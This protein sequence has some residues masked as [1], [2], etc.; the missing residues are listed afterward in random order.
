[1]VAVEKDDERVRRGERRRI[2]DLAAQA[3][4]VGSGNAVEA[5][6]DGGL[7]RSRADSVNGGR[8][9][10]Q[11]AR[12]GHRRLDRD[13]WRAAGVAAV[14][15]VARIELAVASEVIDD[16][17]A[18]TYATCV[19]TQVAYNTTVK[20]LFVELPPFERHRAEYLD[21]EGFS[22]LQDELMTDPDAATSSRERAV[23][24]RC[25]T[26]IR[27]A[28]RA[29]VEAC[30]SSTTGGKQEGSSGSSRCTTRTR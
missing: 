4:V 25:A 5:G 13:R 24:E 7:R 8:R 3:E 26:V 10:R 22:G 23:C 21:D 17:V 29:N 30:A 27:V 6:G 14:E 2:D 11:R 18:L 19:P 1:V 15:E 9:E 28:E 16:V 20:A 12:R